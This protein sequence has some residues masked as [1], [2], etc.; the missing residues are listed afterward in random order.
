MLSQTLLHGGL[1]MFWNM[2]D[3]WAPWA[4]N[5]LSPTVHSG[6][7]SYS[8][9]SCPSSDV[10]FSGEPSWIALATQALGHAPTWPSVPNQ[11]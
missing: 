1:Y 6:F 3:S 4:C 9:Y 5:A 10:P 2:P 8:S 11:G 7:S